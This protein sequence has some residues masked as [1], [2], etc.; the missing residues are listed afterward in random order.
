MTKDTEETPLLESKRLR[1]TNQYNADRMAA[2]TASLQQP[3]NIFGLPTKRKYALLEVWNLFRMAVE[4][5]GVTLALAVLS[6]TINIWTGMSS[7]T[8][9]HALVFKCLFVVFGFLLGFRNVRANNRQETANQQIQTLFTSV[10]TL[11]LLFPEQMQRKRVSRAFI[12]VLRDLTDYVSDMSQR[13]R[14]WYTAIDM[15]P[16]VHDSGTQH[17]A[18]H[19]HGFSGT[20]PRPLFQAV[21][22]MVESEVYPLEDEGTFTKRRMV[23]SQIVPIMQSYDDIIHMCMPAVSDRYAA[24]LDLLLNIFMILL[25]WGL[26]SQPLDLRPGTGYKWAYIPETAMLLITTLLIS[27]MMMGL[28]ALAQENEDPYGGDDD[29]PLC[30]VVDLFEK[31]LDAYEQQREQLGKHLPAGLTT[32]QQDVWYSAALCGDGI[33]CKDDV[34][35]EGLSQELGLP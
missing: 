7:K 19:Q 9:F 25:P 15:R 4:W 1:D 29:M 22:M 20:S 13:H 10:W 32:C 3:Q 11:I 21:L 17:E 14:I 33:S 6:A 26:V 35:L 23:W 28:N 24:L 16:P 8:L 5:H 30:S 2:F 18:G 31:A 12:L 27:C 34:R